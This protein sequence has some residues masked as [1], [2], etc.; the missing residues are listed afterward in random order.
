M[1]LRLSILLFLC[2]LALSASHAFA[3][4]LTV[5]PSEISVTSVPGREMSARLT[6]KNSSRD[7]SFFEVYPDGTESIVKV[8]PAS[9]ILESG[10][11]R[12]VEI[13]VTPRE[14]GRI[15]TL[16]SVVAKPVSAIGLQAGAGVKIPLHIVSE[17]KNFFGLA[18][19]GFLAGDY[20]WYFVVVLGLFLFFRYFR[21][22]L[23]KK[24]A[25]GDSSPTG[26]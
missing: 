12:Q 2:L 15:E 6:V 7:V 14:A 3:V 20:G 4:G 1:K 16:I 13:K 10:A 26:Q 17:S 22:T 23:R 5:R 19:I 11:E 24:N 18:A 9:F 25:N 8:D 21:I